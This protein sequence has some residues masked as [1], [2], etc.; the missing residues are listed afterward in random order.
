MGYGGRL[1]TTP[2]VNDRE[3]P[4]SLLDLAARE[5]C[6]PHLLRQ[7]RQSDGQPLAGRAM[8]RISSP[9]CPQAALLMLDEAY[10]EFA[11]EGTLAAARCLEPQR[12][13]LPHLLQS[14]WHGGHAA[15]LCHRPCRSHHRLRQDPQ[16]LRRH[17]HRPGR[18]PRGIWPIRSICAMWCAKVAAARD[19][20][21]HIARANGLD[22]A[23]VGHQLRHHRLRPRWRLC[24]ERFSIRWS[25]A[26]S[27]SA[28]RAWRP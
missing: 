19:G 28:C 20:N 2:Y 5:K 7:S 1:V 16:S 8:S 27:S 14:L 12:A 23:A 26:A 15:R 10:G 24:Q 13:A 22:A 18:G 17:P 3:D 21:R 6:P 25:P 11:P 9:I 4:A